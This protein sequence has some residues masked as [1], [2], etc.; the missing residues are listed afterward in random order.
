[1]NYL[2]TSLIVSALTNEVATRSVQRWLHQ[3]ALSSFMISD[4][5]ITETSSAISLKVRTG[6]I[7]QDQ[8]AAILAAFNKLVVESFLVV[9]V[10]PAQFHLAAQYAA[11]HE[12]SLR[13]G[14]ALHLAVASRRSAVLCTLDTRLAAAGPAVGV[15]TQLID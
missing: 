5:A 13:A 4:W 2:D 7:D 14:D 1:M 6:Q 3:N 9:P 11:R 15:P 8:S 10:E 12:L